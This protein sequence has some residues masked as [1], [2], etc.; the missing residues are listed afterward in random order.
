VAS[1]FVSMAGI[2]LHGRLPGSRFE[3]NNYIM[4]RNSANTAHFDCPDLLL[5][6]GHGR[7]GG[8]LLNQLLLRTHLSPPGPQET[9]ETT[10]TVVAVRWRLQPAVYPMASFRRS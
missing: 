2:A 6:S 3:S 8:N 1:C 7:L 10:T 4:F 9:W 5:A